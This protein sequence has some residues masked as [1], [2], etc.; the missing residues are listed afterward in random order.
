MVKLEQ[1]AD[2]GSPPLQSA[3]EVAM[4]ILI[5]SAAVG[6]IIGKSGEALRNL[7]IDHHCRIQMS[8][9]SETYPGTSERI[10][11]VKG[12]VQNV[13]SAIEVILKKI[14]EKCDGS[15]TDAFDHKG[16][17][18]G[19]ELLS[20]FDNL[21]SILRLSGFNEASVAE[22]MQAMQVFAK[23]N[24]MGPVLGVGVAAMGQMRS[25]QEKPRHGVGEQPPAVN[26]LLVDV[27][28]SGSGTAANGENFAQT[29]MKE[30]RISNE[31]IELEVPD[32]I[33]GAVL[34]PK[35]K[36]L[37]EIKFY[38]GCKVEVFRR[39]AKADLPVG[40]RLISLTGDEKS[41]RMCRL[42]IERVVN[43]AQERRVGRRT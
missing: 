19:N 10:C 30:H 22:V 29:V 11:L 32:T 43:E 34:G 33:V 40:R 16:V 27:L 18:R 13:L 41:M 36:T 1:E 38:S 37:Q 6:A 15:T 28:R 25:V 26:L 3:D 8:K 17:R 9:R 7:K 42:M 23:H 21:Q 31:A 35:A 20:F 24:I 5:P 12:R 2:G 4:K 14:N 39:G